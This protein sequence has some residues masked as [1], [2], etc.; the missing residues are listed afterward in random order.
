MA[1]SWLQADVAAAPVPGGPR[2]LQLCLPRERGLPGRPADPLRQQPL[3][4][5][6]HRLG[7]QPLLLEGKRVFVKQCWVECF[8]VVGKMGFKIGLTCC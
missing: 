1:S 3:G 8:A 4:R 6:R 7:E 2:E 5:L